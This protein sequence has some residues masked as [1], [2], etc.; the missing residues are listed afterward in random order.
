MLEHRTDF[1]A[2]LVDLLQIGLEPTRSPE[3]RRGR[4]HFARAADKPRRFYAMCQPRIRAN[5]I[6]GNGTAASVATT[7]S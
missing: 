1:A 2:S 4:L 7:T 3:I 6:H 5:T